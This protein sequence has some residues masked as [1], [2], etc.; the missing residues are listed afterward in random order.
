[1]YFS[2]KTCCNRVC[3]GGWVGVGRGGVGGNVGGGVRFLLCHDAYIHV[4]VCCHVW[5]DAGVIQ[6]GSGV[7]CSLLIC[8]KCVL[9]GNVPDSQSWNYQLQCTVWHMSGFCLITSA[10]NKYW[11]YPSSGNT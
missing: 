8:L 4:R 3:V 1:M 2:E 7:I 10:V 5:D 6:K 11:I 9:A